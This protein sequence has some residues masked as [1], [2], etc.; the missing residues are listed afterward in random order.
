VTEVPE[1]RYATTPDGVTIA[2]QRF[3]Q[4]DLDLVYVPYFVFNL[5]LLWDFPP[6]ADWLGRL[7]TFSRVLVHDPRGTGL[8]ERGIEPGDLGT[9][10]RDVLAVLDAEGIERSALFGSLSNGA[11]GALL[12]AT[13]PDRVASLI[14]L[15]AAARERPAEDYPWGES[16]E[17]IAAD[18]DEVERRWGSNDLGSEM[19]AGEGATGQVDAAFHRWMAKMQRGSVTPQ[20]ARA[21]YQAWAETDVRDVLPAVRVPT[22]VLS[23]GGDPDEHRYVASLMPGARYRDL[24]GSDT[25]P[26]FGDTGKLVEAV[27]DFLGVEQVAARPERF[28]ST[29]LFTDIVG[30]TE[31]AAA[32]GDAR[33]RELVSGHHRLIRGLLARHGGVEMDTAGDGF[34]AAFDAPGDAVRCA[35]E[36]VGAVR[37][38]DLEIRAGLH[39]GEVQRVDGKHAGL[40]VAIGARVASKA[41]PSEVLASQTVKDLTAGSGLVFSD[42]GEHDLKGVPDRWRLYRVLP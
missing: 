15:N 26:W 19:A 8:S 29:V 1:T 16:D 23:R 32:A 34:Y 22:L 33:W 40:A 20:R 5:D 42:A 17:E 35:I 27:R 37:A 18:L 14:W 30:S 11:T 28:L 12:A 10:A 3:G 24:G 9:R 6:I 4:G 39:T 2:Y 31:R 21:L 38:L 7:A 36:A 25:M 41:G 13:H